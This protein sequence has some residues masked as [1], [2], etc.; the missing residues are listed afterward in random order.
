MSSDRIIAETTL[1]RETFSQ[2]FPRQGATQRLP[3]KGK[4][5]SMPL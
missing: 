3:A 1:A 2:R 5:I 4:I